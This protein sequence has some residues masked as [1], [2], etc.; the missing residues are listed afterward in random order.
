MDGHTEALSLFT[1]P[2]V[3]SG[4]VNSQIIEYLPISQIGDGGFIEFNV[5]PQNFIDLARS[6]L[7]LKCKVV[8]GDN[9]PVVYIEDEESFDTK[10][11]VSPSNC[12]LGSIFQKIDLCIQQHNITGDVPSHLHP[13]KV[14]LDCLLTEKKDSNI[15]MLYI[16]D[17]S[18]VINSCSNWKLVSSNPDT[19]VE[20]GNPALKKRSLFVN[21][22]QDFEL[23]GSL[24]VDFM[25]QSRLLIHN[26]NIGIKC[27]QNQPEFSLLS[28]GTDEKFKIKILDAKLKLCHV[29]LEPAVSV[30]ISNSL[31]LKPALYPFSSSVLKAHSV[32]KGSQSVTIN[33]PFTSRCP[34]TL[35]VA[36]VK[37]ES[38]NGSYLENP[39]FFYHFNLSDIGFYVNNTPFPAKPMQLNFSDTIHQSHYLEAYERLCIYNPEIN[40]SYEE[41]YRGYTILVFDLKNN[42]GMDLLSNIHRGQTKLELR[43]GKSLE[44]AV[45]VILYGKFNASLTIDSVRNVNLLQQS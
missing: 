22:G 6:K 28:G 4:V 29:N 1:S 30:A 9:T 41:F 43:F 35:F 13:Y 40:I 10:G 11:D 24:G 7:Y 12:L 39:F 2:P 8:C 45:T 5:T 26:V 18:E 23:L 25:T 33:D 17:H 27:V 44:Q 32:P 21:R 36:M 14:M 3:N 15:G 19:K 31:K 37:S 34:E 16:K 42:E 38:Y 20:G